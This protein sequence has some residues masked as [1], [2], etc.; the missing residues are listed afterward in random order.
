M[1]LFEEGGVDVADG[2]ELELDFEIII[3]LLFSLMAE[4]S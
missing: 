1:K 3:L 2:L 4:L